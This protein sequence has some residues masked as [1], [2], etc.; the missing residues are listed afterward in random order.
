MEHGG[1]PLRGCPMI[2]NG[3]VMLRDGLDGFMRIKKL[4]NFVSPVKIVE[5]RRRLQ[6]F[7]KPD[8][9]AKAGSK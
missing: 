6:A 4:T 3:D 1:R 5:S 2:K 8:Q 9:H 7:Q